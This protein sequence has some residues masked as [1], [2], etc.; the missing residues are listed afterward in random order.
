MGGEV[1]LC[2]GRWQQEASPAGRCKGHETAHGPRHGRRT[3]ELQR[4]EGRD[5]TTITAGTPAPGL[6]RLSGIAEGRKDAAASAKDTLG[7]GNGR[8]LGDEDQ[9]PWEAVTPLPARKETSER[10][11]GSGSSAA[12]PRGPEPVVAQPAWA[13]AEH[14]REPGAGLSAPTLRSWQMVP[15]PIPASHFRSSQ[16][17]PSRQV[18]HLSP[19]SSHHPLPHAPPAQPSLAHPRPLCPTSTP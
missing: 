17:F 12:I 19:S 5:A 4:G 9:Q 6:L 3:S 16:P 1:G 7:S 15:A 8:S 11:T 2:V 14:S 10:M 13:G 18:S